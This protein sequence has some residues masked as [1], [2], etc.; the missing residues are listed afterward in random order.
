MKA[1]PGKTIPME[2]F[3]FWKADNSFTTFASGLRGFNFTG[4][5]FNDSVDEGFVMKSGKT[6]REVIFN[7]KKIERDADDDIMFWSFTGVHGSKTFTV[8]IFND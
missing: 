1:F 8:K 7:L 6:G 5:I 2:M 3:A 4:R